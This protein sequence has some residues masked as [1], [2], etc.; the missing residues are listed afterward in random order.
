[1]GILTR[2]GCP[3]PE[4]LLAYEDDAL[5]PA[6]NSAVVAH[7]GTCTRCRERMADSREIGVLLR[8]HVP[9]IDDPE[10]LAELKRRLREGPPP[11]LPRRRRIDAGRA[12]V[13]GVAL[14]ALIGIGLVTSQTIEGGSSF[15]RWFHDDTPVGRTVPG[16]QVSSTPLPGISPVSSAPSL[17]YALA[18]MSGETGSDGTRHY[19]NADGLVIVV[20]TGAAGDGQLR[21]NPESVTTSVVGVNRREVFLVASDTHAGSAV[22][23]F[24][25]IDGERLVSVRVLEQPI[26]GLRAFAAQEI[27]A[28]LMAQSPD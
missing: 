22:I 27:A 20:E 9:V 26:G 17:P 3:R 25:W 1:M 2:S 6:E 19:Q 28:A 24:Y 11:P 8:R 23:A 14:I 16:G 13:F 7:L 4:V 21:T 18:P 12:A 15:T 10:G 5:S